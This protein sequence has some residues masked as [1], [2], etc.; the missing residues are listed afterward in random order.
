MVSITSLSISEQKKLIAQN[1]LSRKLIAKT[2]VIEG[3]RVK[4]LKH[5]KFLVGKLL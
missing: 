2:Q 4:S 3:E 1:K 5:N